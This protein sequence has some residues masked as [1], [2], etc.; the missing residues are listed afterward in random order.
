MDVIA[1][2]P[3]RFLLQETHGS[4]FPAEMVQND[5]SASLG[6]ES[7]MALL[8]VYPLV[9]CRYESY[10]NFRHSPIGS[11]HMKGS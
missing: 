10:N 1:P 11:V 9:I 2:V 6:P 5:L 3:H 8:R 7:E 4:H